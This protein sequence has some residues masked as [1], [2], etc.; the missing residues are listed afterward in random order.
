[1]RGCEFMFFFDVVGLGEGSKL[2][3]AEGVSGVITK[4]ARTLFY[5]IN[6]MIYKLISFLY[7]L[8][9]SLSRAK[10]LDEES[11]A[12]IATKVGLVL[13]MIMLFRVIINFI[14]MLIDPDKINDKQIGATAII[15]KILIVI[16]M[17]GISP[18]FFNTLSYVQNLVLSEKI[19]YKLFLPVEDVNIDTNNFGNV[20]AARTFGTFYTVNEVLVSSTSSTTEDC[21]SYRNLLL[22]NIAKTGND[23]DVGT[24]C[25][26]AYDSVQM[27]DT[28]NSGSNVYSTTYDAFVMDYNYLLQLAV[29]VAIVYL[30]F[31]YV[32]KVGVRVIQLTVLQII[33]PAAII[34][35]LSPKSDNFFTKWWKIYF[36]TYID[37]FIRT[38]IIFFVVYLSSI[39]LDTV[40]SGTNVFWDSVNPANQTTKYTI[41]VVM[42]L[43]LL[44]FAK[45]AP[46][47][48]K[49]LIPA[50]AS[51]LGFG[52]SMK[53]VV[54]LQK[55][56]GMV[57]GAG[58]ASAIGLIGGVAGGKGFSRVTGAFSGVLGGA[59]RGG[60]AGFSSKG[61]VKSVSTAR[62]NQAKANIARAQRIASGAT[63]D[64]RVS[65]ATRG[66]FGIQSVYEKLNAELTMSSEIQA[67][68]EKDDIIQHIQEVR[69]SYIQAQAQ[70]GNVVDPNVLAKFDQ[71]KKDA[72]KQMYEAA[73]KTDSKKAAN[74]SVNI[75][76]NNGRSIMQLNETFDSNRGIYNQIH[77]NERRAR[78][79]LSQWSDYKNDNGELKKK[80]A[81]RTKSGK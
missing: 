16:V 53:D 20:L 12:K 59:I 31:M 48:L 29:G 63:F 75:Q 81:D 60:H 70:S 14:Q 78:K 52:I 66:F 28:S 45:R 9:E 6:T 57:A 22:M 55:G 19:I 62:S 54:G 3:S 26:T 27:Q 23:Y 7:Q 30:L 64:E 13:G 10:L 24:Y 58:T 43:A 77:T 68:L 80:I 74:I 17:F 2:E 25:L 51:K 15:K 4:A 36:S 72:L 42:I 47:L 41:V 61:V 1:M 38:G 5:T 11:F 56:I 32:I 21:V 18:F 44:T 37:V 73:Y 67:T 39:L 79:D 46:E 34:G 8:F 69:Q 71:A 76:D 50:S 40:D 35:Y 65:D 33:S 49:E